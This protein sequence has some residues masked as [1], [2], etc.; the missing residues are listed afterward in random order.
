MCVFSYKMFAQFQCHTQHYRVMQL[1]FQLAASRPL[2]SSA[3]H[4]S[5]VTDSSAVI[6]WKRISI[7]FDLSNYYEYII[8]YKEETSSTWR[9]L[10]RRKHSET[11]P[12]MQSEP[13][14]GLTHDTEYDVRLT[15]YRVM[16][17]N[18]EDTDSETET[19][20]TECIGKS[21]ASFASLLKC[22]DLGSAN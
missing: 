11:T 7:S 18:P 1:S 4:V 22:L 20:K 9:E 16:R 15:S 17:S 8:E 12:G 10:L 21:A 3:L 2:P 13:L 6:T 19:F 14:N 5:S